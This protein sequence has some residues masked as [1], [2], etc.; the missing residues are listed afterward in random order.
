M[1]PISRESLIASLR[2]CHGSPEGWHRFLADVSA[3]FGSTFSGFARWNRGD[4]SD[5]SLS[6]G[7][8]D[9]YLRAYHTHWAHVN[10]WILEGQQVFGVGNEVLPTEALVSQ[11]RFVRSDF[12]NDFLA[13]ENLG[14]YG[15]AAQIQSGREKIH[16]SLVR[17]AR[18]GPFGAT[19]L[20]VISSLVPHIQNAIRSDR[21][22]AQLRAE[23]RVIRDALD[24]LPIGL[25]IV[26]RP[27]F[28][29]TRA[30]RLVESW[31]AVLAI[32]DDGL[33][34]G[35]AA[36]DEA[37]R[38]RVARARI[39]SDVPESPLTLTVNEKIAIR[40]TV[41]AGFN[42]ARWAERR[43][44][45][46]TLE[47]R[48]PPK[49]IEHQLVAQHHLTYKEAELLST[50]HRARDLREAADQLGITWKTARVHLARTF[51]KMG[52]HS[53]RAVVTLVDR[54]G[55]EQ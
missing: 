44:P 32:S 13:R 37:L 12:Y 29:N 28:F 39:L 24:A 25:V 26:D 9:S 2:D 18:W 50:L 33:R 38:R 10:P 15:A 21:F 31:P 27:P 53:Q 52:V 51:K 55:T 43:P 16:L 22:A 49:G 11:H 8:D 17:T 42:N 3:L 35:V 48:R 20:R 30:R 45:L 1:A 46:I 36:A 7:V 6:F 40:I 5:I 4:D 19:E 14:R 23:C 54:M 34:L 41:I 47:V